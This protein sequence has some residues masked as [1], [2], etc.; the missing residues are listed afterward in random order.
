MVG[1]LLV[2]SPISYAVDFYTGHPFGI[3]KCEPDGSATSAM[4]QWYTEYVQVQYLTDPV[5]H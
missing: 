3:G 1:S 5:Y 2:I 4:H